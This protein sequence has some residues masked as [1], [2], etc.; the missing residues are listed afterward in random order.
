VSLLL[1]LLTSVAAAQEKVDVRTLRYAERAGYLVVSGTFTDAFDQSLLEQL[2]SGFA[3]TVAVHLFVYPAG[4]DQAIWYAAATYRAVYSVWDEVYLVRLRDPAGERNLRFTSRAEALKAL[5]TLDSFPLAP[6][7]A[8]PVGPRHFTAVL[9]EVN[10]VGAE[11]LAEVRRWLVRPRGANV[12]GDASFFGSFVSV[13][14]NPKLAAA[15]RALRF[16]SQDFYRVAA[17][18]TTTP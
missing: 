15:D 13:F 8:I 9:V 14:V 17:P 12:G 6:L 2:S 18:K 16:R 4:S 7:A 5:T 3:Q 1:L 10:P 11:L